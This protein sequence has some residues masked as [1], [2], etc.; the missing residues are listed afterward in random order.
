MS[1]F[2]EIIVHPFEFTVRWAVGGF[3]LSHVF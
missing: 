3:Y 1:D 2:R